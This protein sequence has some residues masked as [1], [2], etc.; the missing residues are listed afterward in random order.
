MEGMGVQFTPGIGRLSINTIQTCLGLW[1][2]LLG[3][4]AS[5]NNPKKGFNPPLASHPFPPP[6]QPPS[7]PPTPYNMPSVILQWF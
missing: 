5:P 6:T 4:I 7:H 3:P 2:A 1:L